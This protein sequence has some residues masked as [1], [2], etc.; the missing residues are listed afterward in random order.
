MDVKMLET[1]LRLAKVKGKEMHRPWEGREVGES[2]PGE[3]R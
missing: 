1:L 3:G 2:K